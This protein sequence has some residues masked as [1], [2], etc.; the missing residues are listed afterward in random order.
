MSYIEHCCTIVSWAGYIIA[1]IYDIVL[2]LAVDF[3]VKSIK[4]ISMY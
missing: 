3:L 1:G 4:Y 2:K